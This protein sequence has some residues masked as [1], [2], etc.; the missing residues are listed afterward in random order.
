MRR[1]ALGSSTRTHTVGIGR[2]H[3]LQAVGIGDPDITRGLPEERGLCPK[4][5]V[6]VLVAVSPVWTANPEATCTCGTAELPEMERVFDGDRARW[7]ARR[8]HRHTP[9]R[10]HHC[11]PFVYE[12]AHDVDAGQEPANGSV[13]LC[14]ER[15]SLQLRHD[16]LWRSTKRD[17]QDGWPVNGVGGALNFE[18]RRVHRFGGT[19]PA[20]TG[21]AQCHSGQRAGWKDA[22]ENEGSAS[23]DDAPNVLD[24]R[25]G[26]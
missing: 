6:L 18:R 16:S 23:R 14:S 10:E 24:D 7:V 17:A 22:S 13:T 21:G 1:L 20:G 3:A 26:A 12:R 25:R 5:G 9:G 15:I 19:L 8:R 11:A 2:V 4:L